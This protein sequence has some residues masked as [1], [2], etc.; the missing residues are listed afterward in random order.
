MNHV[1][2]DLE[3]MSTDPRAAILQIGACSFDPDT[4][5]VGEK[6]CTDV[7]LENNVGAFN[8]VI[9]PSTILWWLSPSGRA[10]KN[11][12]PEKVARRRA[13][14]AAAREAMWEAQLNAIPLSTA[15]HSFCLWLDKCTVGADR[16]EGIWSHGASFDL[17]ILTTAL[18]D[19]LGMDRPPWDYRAP[20]DTRTVFWLANG[21]ASGKSYL[22]LIPMEKCVKHNAGDDA[23]RQALAI[24]MAVSDIKHGLPGPARN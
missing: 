15:L 23:L 3:T 4:R 13:E 19:T 8:R 16:L 17:P 10:E 9:D 24:C 5:Q 1:M 20:R 11:D 21:D 22:D 7:L 2:V 14:M 6:F 18:K 12:T